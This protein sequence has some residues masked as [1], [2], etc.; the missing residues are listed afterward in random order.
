MFEDENIKR[1]YVRKKKKRDPL[2]A[3]SHKQGGDWLSVPFIF[4]SFVPASS[5]T[6]THTHLVN[7]SGLDP[8]MFNTNTNVWSG[9]SS[10]QPGYLGV[11]KG[12]HVS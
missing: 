12:R 3:L 8:C 11:N 1:D 5:N 10:K 6:R 4:S 7:L 9:G 2:L